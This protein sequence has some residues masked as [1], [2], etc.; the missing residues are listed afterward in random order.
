MEHKTINIKLKVW[1]QRNSK[2]AGNF[3]TYDVNDVSTEMSFLEMI[4]VLNER[5][6]REG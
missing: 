6:I 3:E 2:S 4:D 5:L 1:R